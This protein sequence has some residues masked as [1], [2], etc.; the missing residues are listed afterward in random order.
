MSEFM[1]RGSLKKWLSEQGEMS[2]IY[3]KI[4]II[5]YILYG[6]TF[7]HSKKVLHMDL[8]PMNILM[9]KNLVPKITDFGSAFSK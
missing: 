8:K 6:L 4:S 1:R 7:V 3:T 9:D 5:L 2:S